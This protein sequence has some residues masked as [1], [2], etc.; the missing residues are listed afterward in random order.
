M[1]KASE[2]QGML[3]N[4]TAVQNQNPDTVLNNVRTLA[5]VHH[6]SSINLVCGICQ[7][8]IVRA[9]H[10]DDA[11]RWNL[12]RS[13]D[14]LKAQLNERNLKQAMVYRYIATGLELARAIVKRF[15]IGSGVMGEIFLAKHETEAFKAIV[16][17]VESN[18]YLPGEPIAAW[19]VDAEQRPRFSLDV[20]RVNL[21]LDKLDPTKQ[22]G[23]TAPVPAAP[24][25]ALAVTPT[26]P[27]TQAKPASIIAR[28]K[29]D[30]DVLSK[31]PP[32]IIMAA[33]DKVVGREKMAERLIGLC[34]LDECILLQTAI[35]ERMKALSLIPASTPAAAEVGAPVEE[36]KT[37]TRRRRSRAA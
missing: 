19:S 18:S 3:T 30:P 4:V 32:E 26:A 11:Q 34:T 16:K 15:G 37:T 25:A 8:L 14:F 7:F 22:P 2:V 12:E 1:A 35:S 31:A 36:G 29:A 20:L 6:K 28:L 10:Q 17:C 27:A 9:Y 23:Y 21:G 5:D 33:V 13:R 24:G